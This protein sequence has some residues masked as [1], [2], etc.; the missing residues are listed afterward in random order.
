MKWTF[1]LLRHPF[2]ERADVRFLVMFSTLP[3]FYSIRHLSFWPFNIILLIY[4]K[5]YNDILGSFLHHIELC[6]NRPYVFVV[7]TMQISLVL[8]YRYIINHR[9]NMLWDTKLYFGNYIY[10]EVGT[11]LQRWHEMW[12]VNNNAIKD[13]NSS[14]PK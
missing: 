1:N 6:G 9:L 7:N 12:H 3:M 10:L 4:L 5:C 8:L 13:L 11:N 2:R 14:N